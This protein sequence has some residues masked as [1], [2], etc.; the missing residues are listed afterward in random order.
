M[1]TFVAVTTFNVVI[2]Y[3][4]VCVHVCAFPITLC[5]IARDPERFIVQMRDP[6]DLNDA[7]LDLMD[8]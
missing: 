4:Y 8:D 3:L 7:D 5:W 2:A 1:P 6:E